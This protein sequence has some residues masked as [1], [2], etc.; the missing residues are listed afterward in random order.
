MFGVEL[1][2]CQQ[3]LVTLRWHTDFGEARNMNCTT[4]FIRFKCSLPSARTVFAAIIIVWWLFGRYGRTLRYLYFYANPAANVNLNSERAVIL[5]TAHL[6]RVARCYER[7]HA[8]KKNQRKRDR[9]RH[10]SPKVGWQ[11]I[12]YKKL[13]AQCSQPDKN[14]KQ[15]RI[16]FCLFQH[17]W[18]RTKQE[19]NGETSKT[20]RTKCSVAIGNFV[21]REIKIS[22]S[23]ANY[24]EREHQANLNLKQQRKHGRFLLRRMHRHL[25]HSKCLL[26]DWNTYQNIDN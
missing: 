19:T 9:R 12:E 3:H 20:R 23:N 10:R 11:H 13:S 17:N 2:H 18:N 7:K 4:R 25:R 22:C 6:N 8:D 14:N 24:A 21:K 16:Y 15:Q 26:T 1:K 5:I